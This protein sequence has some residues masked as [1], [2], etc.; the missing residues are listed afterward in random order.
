MFDTW[1]T[2][3]LDLVATAVQ[4]SGVDAA[5]RYIGI[6][7][8]CGTLGASLSLGTSYT[9]L[10]L[11]GTLPANLNSGQ[12]LV[13][14]DGTNSQS[15]VTNGAATAGATTIAVVA[16]T[17]SAN[18]TSGVTGIAPVPQ[19]SDIALYNETARVRILANGAGALPGE[20]L[21]SGYCDGTQPSNIYVAVGYFGGSSATSSTGTGTL[22]GAG[23]QFWNHTL[24]ADTQMY[25]ADAII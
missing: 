20:T 22:I 15:V 4:A 3:G 16:F 6:S 25:Q 11:T 9:S 23:I 7:T 24:N 14:T 10:T 21:A 13:L 19:S 12:T 2:G 5:I 1:T 18:F 8:G 17:A